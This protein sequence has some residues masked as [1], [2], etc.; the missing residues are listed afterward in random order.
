MSPISQIAIVVHHNLLRRGLVDLLSDRP[1]L[2]VVTAVTEPSELDLAVARCDVI[3]FGP[4]SAAQNGLTESIGALARHGR[5]LIVSDFSGGRLVVGALQAGAY[6]CVTTLT[7][8]DELLHAVGTVARGGLHVAP[9]LADRLHGELRHASVT[10]PPPL[11][12]REI[13]ALRWLAAG[14]TH[15]QIGR[16]MALTEATVSTYIKRIKNKLN[17]GNKADL[18]RK[19]MELGLLADEQAEEEEGPLAGCTPRIEPAA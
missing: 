2:R 7:D 12:P 5:V 4:S 3:V 10:T 8:D 6:G 11:A 18:T 16:R 1:P 19:A 17:V 9:G 14:L 15:R 13:Q